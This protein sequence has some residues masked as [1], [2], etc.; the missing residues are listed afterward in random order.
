[1]SRYTGPRARVSRRLGTNI[2]GTKG[3]TIALDKR[4][5]P[6]G[7]HGRTRRRPNQSEYLLQL[8]EKQ[9]ARFSYG[10]TEKQFRRLYEEANRREGVTGENML[11]FLELR[12]DNVVYRA[13]LAATRPQ[14]RQMVNHGHLDVN[15]RRVDIP[16][17]RVRK[18]DVVS[19]RPKARDMV[20]V[21]WN[22]DVLDRQAPAWL[23]VGGDGF[24]VTVRELPVRDQIDIPVRE[25]LI[26]ELYSK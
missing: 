4:P 12:L 5:Y 14:A 22:I 25:H 11:R 19:L 8:Q 10:L 1:M 20:I 18:G 16:S 15:G 23:D 7:E 9:K 21:R 6:P 26:V 17:F 3:E 2:F 13:G 24:E